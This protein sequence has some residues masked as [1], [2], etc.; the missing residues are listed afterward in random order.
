MFLPSLQGMMSTAQRFID[1]RDN[2]LCYSTAGS[3]LTP[4]LLFH[5][6]GQSHRVFEEWEK[7]LGKEYRLF[8]FDLFF[9]G[10]SEWPNRQTLEKSDWKKIIELFLDQEKIGRFALTG[11]SLGGKFAL[12]VL[13]AFPEKVTTLYL[14]APDGIK[15]SMWYSLATYP[16]VI[17]KLFKSL[18]LRP[19]RFYDT[20]R[21][22]R[23]LG[24]VNKG[25]L[26]FAESQ[27]DSE[28]KRRRVYLSW[29]YFRHL[30]FDMKKIADILNRHGI[31]LVMI[32]G[33]F[34]KVIPAENMD[35]LMKRLDQKRL[36]V[37][38]TGHNNLIK[39]AVGFLS[40][41]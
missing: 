16:F 10:Q 12:A 30:K 31:P 11:Y 17:R 2:R 27:M 22:L 36:E 32:V 1:F 29:V 25:I 8:A 28:E 21:I 38:D 19:R 34:D 20:V 15:T 5:G 7:A 41:E 6:F 14:I 13:E 24:I 18:I 33:K 37:I 23:S 40:N 26:R 35:R 39:N 4:L 9:H 3:G